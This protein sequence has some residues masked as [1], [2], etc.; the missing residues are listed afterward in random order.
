M[1]YIACRYRFH[2]LKKYRYFREPVPTICSIGSRLAT[3]TVAEFHLHIGQTRIRPELYNM[4]SGFFKSDLLRG[5]LQSGI[6]LYLQFHIRTV[7]L[8]QHAE[9]SGLGNILRN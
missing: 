1:E 9:R 3:A 2:L 8:N 7:C 4:Q 5:R 6:T